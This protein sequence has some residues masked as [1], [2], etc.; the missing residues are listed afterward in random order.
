MRKIM[1]FL[2]GIYLA[3]K[4]WIKNDSMDASSQDHR[5]R[6]GNGAAHLHA[7]GDAL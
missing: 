1:D 2:E 4:V 6:I 3:V 5:L 7:C